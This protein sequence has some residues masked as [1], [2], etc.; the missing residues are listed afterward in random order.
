MVYAAL[1]TSLIEGDIG[2]G[3]GCLSADS[4]KVLNP[5]EFQ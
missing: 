5:P 3:G 4:K 2:D 1:H